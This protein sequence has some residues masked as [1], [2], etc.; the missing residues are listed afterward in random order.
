MGDVSC[1]ECVKIFPVSSVRNLEPGDHVI[2]YGKIY[3]HHAIVISLEDGE[4]VKIAEAT[5][6]RLRLL[7]GLTKFFG[8]KAL[9]KVSQRRYDFKKEKIFVVKYKHRFSKEKTVR[10]ALMY[11]SEVEENSG[12]KYNLFANNCEHFATYCATGM[13]FS[14]QVTKLMVT[15]QL[16]LTSGIDG[17]D[18]ELV[19]NRRLFVDDIICKECYEKNRKLVGVTVKPIISEDDVKEGDIIRYVYMNLRHEGVVLSKIKV[20]S[21]AVVCT[22]AHYAFCGIFS[23]RT[24]KED[25]EV[26]RLDGRCFKLD[27]APPQ[28]DVYEP[29][30]VVKRARR[31]LGEQTFT[32]FSNDSS[33]YA[34]WCKLKI[35]N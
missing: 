1:I 8:A 13:G 20:S 16:F 3:D 2:S 29:E 24:I 4:S 7:I 32:F 9:I 5:N 23:H 25:R 27:Y 15:C 17:L 18:N 21:I 35:S 6:S 28:Y 34:R 14:V 19:R 33:H 31:R 30:E 11:H 10:R 26:I 22:I 12:Y